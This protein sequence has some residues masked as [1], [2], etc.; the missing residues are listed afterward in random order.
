MAQPWAEA[1]YHSSMWRAAR[2][3]YMRKPIETGGGV[4]PPGMCE[5]CFS[6]G[7]LKPANTVH[8]IEWLTPSTIGDP[9][10]TLSQSN[11]MRVCMDCHAALHSGVDEVPRV[12]FDADGNVV[13]I[14]LED[15]DGF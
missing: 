4:C 11:L 10:K 1:F 6:M 5:R 9:D 13:R 7:V 8:H 3:A 12:A 2:E 15:P 14:G